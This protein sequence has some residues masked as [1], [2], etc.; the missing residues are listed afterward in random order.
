MTKELKNML[1]LSGSGRNVGKTTL[2]CNLIRHLSKNRKVYGL[3]LSPHFHKMN[4]LQKLIAQ[5]EGYK[6]YREFDLD[7]GKDSAKMLSAGANEVYF[8]QCMD[9][10]I[11]TAF[12][13]IAK[14]IPEDIIVVC[15][16]GSLARVYKAGLHLLVEGREIDMNK[17]SYKTNL[18]SN[19]Y[20]IKASDFDENDIAFE[21]EYNGIEWKLTNKK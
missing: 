15:E 11:E 19:D 16:S 2:A 7:S 14:S 21:I 18:K 9:E 1:L 5:G 20:I 8:I 4:H 12:E 3:K 6:V 10:K 13:S 17:K